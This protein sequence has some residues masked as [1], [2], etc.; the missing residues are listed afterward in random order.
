LSKKVYPHLVA[1]T[2]VTRFSVPRRRCLAPLF[3]SAQSCRR[4]EWWPSGK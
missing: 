2:E 3:I 1:A 4:V